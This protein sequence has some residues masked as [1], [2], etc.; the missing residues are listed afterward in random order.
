MKILRDKVIEDE[1]KSG[2]GSLYDDDKTSHQH[3]NL[4]KTKYQQMRRKFERI[5]QE[6]AK[7]K[8]KVKGQEFV[9]ESQI[10]I[11]K[12]QNQ[13]LRNKKN[14]YASQ[15]KSELQDL[16]RE[17]TNTRTERRDLES[18]LRTLETNILRS[19]DEHYD[20]KMLQDG[21]E[22]SE[23]ELKARHDQEVTLLK[24]LIDKKTKEFD[25]ITN[26]CN[27]ITDA[28]ATKEPR[29]SALETATK[30]RA[31][32]EEGRVEIQELLIKVKML[33]EAT[34][35]LA[36]RKEELAEETK[37]AESKNSDLQSQMKAQH[38]I[39]QKRMQSK[40]NRNKTAEIRELIANQEMLMQYAKDL[41]DKLRQ[42]REN[43][44]K[45]LTGKMEAEEKLALKKKQLEEDTET[46]EQQ[47]ALLADLKA[48][49]DAEQATS[50]EQSEKV[51]EARS[52][53][54]TEDDK[55]RHLQQ[56]NTALVAKK[57]FIEAN[58]DY[59]SNVSEMNL[60]IFKGVVQ[61]NDQVNNTVGNFV[62]KVDDV[63]KEVQ[64][65][66]VSRYQL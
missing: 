18:E 64:K 25:S 1:R 35:F 34:E 20:H 62:T 24:E 13:N 57:N 11:M 54:K 26:E 19:G 38:E 58:Y 40:L 27:K 46:V 41:S 60:E 2:I 28:F 10:Q 32:A 36:M 7:T 12:E 17:V 37:I 21:E 66:L 55:H 9:L 65:I 30:L 63:K 56:Q 23:E 3:I 50:D 44:D 14:E 43:Y 15:M 45:L 52:V 47:D 59:T 61:S 6:K 5:I 42:E 16:D 31:Q 53:N 33:T 48:K 4:L 51:A 49:I 39:A 8:L 22:K 29:K